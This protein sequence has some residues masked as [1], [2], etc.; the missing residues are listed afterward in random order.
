MIKTKKL[1]ERSRFL[2]LSIQDKTVI[3]L[4]IVEELHTK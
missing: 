3:I 2:G 1:I 4:F